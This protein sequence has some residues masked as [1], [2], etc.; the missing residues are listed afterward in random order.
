MQVSPVTLL[1]TVPL[2]VAAV[3]LLFLRFSPRILRL[4]T[5]LVAQMRSAPA[6]LAVAQ[7]ERRPHPAM[8]IVILL[9]LALSSSSFLFALI[10]TKDQYNVDT[11]NFFVEGAD[12]SGSLP[13][14]V[15]GTTPTPTFAQLQAQYTGLSGVQSVTLG[16]HDV[17]QLSPEQNDVLGQGSIT[18]NAVDASTYAR[19]IDWATTYSP[20]SSSD[21][22]AQL[23]SH[24]ADA[25]SRNVVYALVD[26]AMWQAYH[27]SPGERFSLLVDNANNI[28]ISFIALAE[29]NT[30][31]GI[32]DTPINP[33]NGIGLLVD[34]QSYATV[35]AK[36][37]R[38]PLAP[39]V[40]WL[41][42]KSDP[43]SLTN[44]RRIFPNLTDRRQLIT[45]NQE[46]NVHLDIIGIL[47]IG[48]GVVLVLALI[49]TLLSSWLSATS[50]RTNFAIMRA[51]G[52]A[53]R[54]IA[55]ILLWEQSF[56]YTLAFALGL[57]LGTMLTIFAAPTVS[58]LD[59]AGPNGRSNPYD[60]PPVLMTIPYIHILL[61]LGIVLVIFVGALVFMA[62]MVSR[63][64]M[65][66]MLRLGED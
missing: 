61:V 31:P 37:A 2:L 60:V 8:R 53:P 57:S 23:A 50:R 18:I 22:M 44:I 51:L 54:Q 36:E 34:Y 40:M 15:Q 17:I 43:A 62:R 3:L 27:L 32:Y 65:S 25:T 14:P 35:Y 38:T 16:Y 7:I 19:T 20:Q 26:S 63:P 5:A 4:S 64:S 58:L 33:A 13:T 66:V 11:A 10:A 55:A 28:H 41:R 52:M 39:N 59:L 24:R 29:V 21:L 30:I 49:G 45:N 56:I 47:T 48:T 9:T 6:V 42:T 12:F 46:N 1:C